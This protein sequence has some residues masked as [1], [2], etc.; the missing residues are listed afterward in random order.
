VYLVSAAS[1]ANS[2]MFLTPL[3]PNITEGGAA[4]P[5][6]YP[7]TYNTGWISQFVFRWPVKYI[8]GSLAQTF[9]SARL[10][11]GF[12]ACSTT[13][14][15]TKR[16]AKFIGLR[17]DTDPGTAL[18]LTQVTVSGST[19]TYTG[20]ITGGAT[21]AANAFAG[22]K[23]VVTGFS[24][25]G[26]N[27][28]ITVTA[29]TAT[30]LV[31]TTSAQVNETHA[32]TATGPRLADSTYKF[33][34]YQNA[35]DGSNIQGT[36]LDTGI[37]P[38]NNWHRLTIR[39]IVQGQILMSLDGGTE[40]EIS[41]STDNNQGFST[42]LAGNSG[43][44]TELVVADN[45][46]PAWYSAPAWGTPATVSGGTSTAAVF[47]GTWTVAD[48]CPTST[49]FSVEM[50]PT[51]NS[52]ASQSGTNIVL[53]W[54]NAFMPTIIFGNNGTTSSTGQALMLDYFSFV[55]NP[56]LATDF[57]QTANA[58]LPRFFTGQT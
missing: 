36:V 49:S 51:V 52:S 33:E 28:T 31:C 13:A 47:N 53:N 46:G 37:A 16:P 56:G 54:Y 23:F 20:T 27:V 19:T 22:A 40:S 2:G 15:T 21:P 7:I 39:S 34:C 35:A 17:Y 26:N 29:S 12:S 4:F 32:G 11:L 42:Q 8:A 10:Y 6:G 3:T 18:T 43:I 9:T 5:I 55:Y 14:G 45:G 38:D 48:F 1:T 44:T 25:A 41:I 30:T 24:N 50:Y 57:A 58:T